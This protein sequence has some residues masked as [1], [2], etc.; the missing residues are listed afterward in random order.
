MD[1]VLNFPPEKVFFTSDTHF[2][3]QNIIR[4]CNRPFHNAEEMN[5]ELIHRWQEVV[6]HDGI[7]FHLGDFCLG[8]PSLW[9]RIL[10]SLPGRKY[11]ILGNHDMKSTSPIYTKQFELVT[12]QMIIRVGHQ[13]IILNHYPLLCYCGSYRDEWQL[14]G[15][16]HSGPVSPGGL[17]IPRLRMLFPLQ[18]DV[19]VD[20]NDYRPISFAQVKA[21]IEGQIKAS[22]EA[23]GIIIEE[24]IPKVFR[25]VFTDKGISIDPALLERLKKVATH[26]IYID[27]SDPTPL[28]ETISIRVSLFLGN[29]HFVYLGYRPM[30]TIP[31]VVLAPGSSVTTDNINA[32]IDM[33][34]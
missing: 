16:V 11:L 18:Y 32:A 26:I 33:I 9:N 4:Y 15:H 28:K 7:V 2:G 6:P 3:H 25:V 23:A 10:S 34:A 27:P 21:K 5:A 22:R 17:D 1:R 19:G 31:C 14:F 30:D 8:S 13:T 24:P 12:Q 29:T 20:N